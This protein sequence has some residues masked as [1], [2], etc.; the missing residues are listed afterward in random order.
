MTE[1]KKGF[2]KGIRQEFKKIVWPTKEETMNSALVVF[3]SLAAVSVFIKIIDE[4][5]RFLLNLVV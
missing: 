3:A 5:L 1:R 4:I 2:L